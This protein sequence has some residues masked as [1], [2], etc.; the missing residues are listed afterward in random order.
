MAGIL[1][2][3]LL[4]LTG[5]VCF[6]QDTL[7]LSL[8]YGNRPINNLPAR[9]D[10]SVRITALRFYLSSISLKNAGKPVWKENN[11]YHLVDVEEPSSLKI[12]LDHNGIHDYDSI[13]FY[14]GIDSAKSESGIMDGDLDPLHGMFWT[15][16]SGYIHFKMEGRH[17]TCPPPRHEF[18]MHV[19]GYRYP[20][21][22]V[23]KILLPYRRDITQVLT[24]DI[25]RFLDAV[26]VA[27]NADVM[28]PGEKAW[29]LSKLIATLFSTEAK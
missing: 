28:S 11:G 6:A 20:F 29:K 3:I 7:S 21:S 22:T 10:D 4:M 2:F 15:W 26:S 5:P 18:V 16:Q 24:V 19:G 1:L 13:E 14:I 12:P 9:F 8:R 17:P 23:Q 25:R 27:D